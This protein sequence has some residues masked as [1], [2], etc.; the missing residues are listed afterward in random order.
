M[1]KCY[2]QII[3]IQKLINERLMSMAR[4]TQKEKI[5][6]LEREL[7]QANKEI[8]QL[9]IKLLNLNNEITSMQDNAD[10]GFENSSEYIQMQK[11]IKVLE[12]KNNSLEDTIKH[13]EKIQ[14]LNNEKVHN[15][16]GAGR[17]QEIAEE[18]R[19]EIKRHRA[20]GKTIKEI[21]TLFNR[22]VGIIHKII[23]EK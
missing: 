7:I 8:Q 23:N 22:S 3:E 5:E 14:K 9:N 12:L 13:N 1:I 17:K 10:N 18:E 16:R 11:R 15:E 19:A 6:R 4:E 2:N 21:A 20:E